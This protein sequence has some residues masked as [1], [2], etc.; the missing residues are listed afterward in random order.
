MGRFVM[1]P[2][3][4]DVLTGLQPRRMTVDHKGS[5]PAEVKRIQ[6]AGG[7]VVLNR[8]SGILAVTRR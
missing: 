4:G 8:V 2:A 1:E 7:L 5:D 6:D 3:F